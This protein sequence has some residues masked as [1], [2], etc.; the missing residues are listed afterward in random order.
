[1][2]VTASEVFKGKKANYEQS[3]P[4]PFVPHRLGTFLFLFICL[5]VCLFIYLFIYFSFLMIDIH[6]LDSMEL[7]SVKV[8]ILFWRPNILLQAYCGI[9]I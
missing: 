2:K 6:V 1:M 5:F 3:I 4:V 9:F 8:S 7:Y